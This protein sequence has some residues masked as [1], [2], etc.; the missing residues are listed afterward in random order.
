MKAVG[1]RTD[2]QRGHSRRHNGFNDRWDAMPVAE[3]MANGANLRSVWWIS[4]A[5][6]EDEHFAVMPEKVARIC[7]LAGCPAGGTILDPF[8][9]AGTTLAVAQNVH[10]R[11]IG[12]EIE[13]KY[14]EIAAKRLSQEVLEFKP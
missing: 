1:G 7:A 10:C 9:G 11:A 12:I 5:Q 8:A 14:C 4:P 13:E 3:Q 2:K 6:F